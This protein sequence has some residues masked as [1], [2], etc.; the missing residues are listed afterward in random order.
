MS[1]T[2][3]ISE[4]ERIFIT[5]GIDVNIRSDGR[6]CMDYRNIL[7]EQ[8]VNE[9]C[10]GSAHARSGNT[11]VLV[12]IKLEL[13]EGNNSSQDCEWDGKSGRVQ[14]FADISAIASPSFEGRKGEDVTCQLEALFAEFLPQYLDLEKLIVV[15]GKS[16][17]VL[18]IDIVILECSSFSS[19]IDVT[20][21]AIKTALFD[22]K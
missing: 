13:E 21:I 4:G 20:S 15:P 7:I 3:Q 19:L 9:T 8:N 5:H 12:G 1:T 6:S 17:F 10:N 2:F 16:Y 22:V 11:D 14:I 18:H